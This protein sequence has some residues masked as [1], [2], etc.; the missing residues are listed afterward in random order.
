MIKLVIRNIQYDVDEGPD[1]KAILKDLPK[2]LVLELDYEYANVMEDKR[3]GSSLED[4][5]E[6][7][8]D[9]ISDTTGYCHKGF[10]YTIKRA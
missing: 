4:I 5:E 1:R 2:K 3:N 9:H 7:V 10:T 6:A 8:S